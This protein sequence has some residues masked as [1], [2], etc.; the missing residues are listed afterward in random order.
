MNEAHQNFW[1]V[2]HKPIIG[3]SPMDGVS[4]FPFRFI[5]KKYGNPTIVYTEF[6]SVEGMTHGST[7]FLKEFM[8]EPAQ[9]P[10]VAQ[11]FGTDP[12][13]FYEAAIV[14]C[15][16]GFDGVDIN[17]GCPAKNVAHR[18]A[19]A[20]LIKTPELAQEIIK[21]VKHAVT[22]WANG[23]TLDEG[24]PSLK[25]KITNEVK[26]RHEDL[27][28]NRK[29]RRLLP[30]SVKTRKG[31][32]R[33]QIDEWIPNLLAVEPAAI[34]VHGRTLTQ[35][36][37]GSAD[38]GAI[39]DAAKLVH[40]YNASHNTNIIILGNGD[41][42]SLDDAYA[43]IAQHGVDGVLI[44]RSTFGNPFVFQG[45]DEPTAQELAPIALEHSHLFEDAFRTQEKYNFL[46]MRKHLGWYIRGVPNATQIRIELFQANSAS[47]VE[48]ILARHNLL[49]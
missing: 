35:H 1:Q 18:G 3:L 12:K 40:E 26:L 29:Q 15:E 30:V 23:K 45:K 4:D 41:I 27:P 47:E 19:G 38:W 31:Y 48:E 5:Q 46:P 10:V 11:I 16:L 25:K 20:G 7:A 21:S 13:A 8:Y 37:G 9:G 42:A 17:M 33:N 32:D 28:E 44:G 49:T 36:Y 6:S 34:A 43:K 39:A 22:D 24:A 14:I 2:L